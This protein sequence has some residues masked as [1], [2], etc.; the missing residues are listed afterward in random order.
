MTS[1]SLLK[2]RDSQLYAVTAQTAGKALVS[3]GSAPDE[4]R[5]Y[6]GAD[7]RR[8]ECARFP[9]GQVARSLRMTSVSGSP[10]R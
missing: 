2:G 7:T 1:D 3:S 5:R 6:F 9:F 10:S 8:G 4:L